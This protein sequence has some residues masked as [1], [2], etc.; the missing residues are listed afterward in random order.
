MLWLFVGPT[1]VYL[2]DF[3]CSSIQFNLLLSPYPCFVSL[4]KCDQVTDVGR[5]RQNT[6]IHCQFRLVYSKMG[7]QHRYALTLKTTAKK[8]S[9]NSVSI[10][11]LLQI[12]A[13][14]I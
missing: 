3:F 1:G 8:S 10:C 6:A 9:E 4:V 12:F 2:L 11:R 13:N 14:I 7:K 5:V